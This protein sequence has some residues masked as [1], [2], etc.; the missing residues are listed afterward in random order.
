MGI[1]DELL[2]RILKGAH[3]TQE[4]N[5]VK[6]EFEEH[7]KATEFFDTLVETYEPDIDALVDEAQEL[8]S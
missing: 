1:C 5:T 7:S 4:E 6:V 8:S 2:G 3:M